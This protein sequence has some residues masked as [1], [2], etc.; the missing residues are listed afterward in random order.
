[1]S[2]S[3]QCSSSGGDEGWGS[4]ESLQSRGACMSPTAGPVTVTMTQ[5]LATEGMACSR[6]SGTPV[7]RRRDCSSSS[8]GK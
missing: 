6:L 4:P 7:I 8:K 2:F 3:L 1:M 5:M